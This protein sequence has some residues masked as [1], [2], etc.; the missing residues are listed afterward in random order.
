[1]MSLLHSDINWCS[2]SLED[3]NI[4]DCYRELP[5]VPI[6]GINGGITYNPCLALRQFDYAQRDGPHDALVQGVVVGYENDIKGYR[7]R[8]V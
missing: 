4:I 2:R 6:F 8:F 3:V 5:N 1:M 7:Q